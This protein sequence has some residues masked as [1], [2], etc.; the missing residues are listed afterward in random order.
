MGDEKSEGVQRIEAMKLLTSKD[1]QT[2]TVAWPT[3][4]LCLFATTIY[5]MTTYSFSVGSLDSELA[6]ITINAFSIFVLFTP[7]HDRWVTSKIVFE[8]LNRTSKCP[9]VCGQE[10][11]Q[12]SERF[13]GPPVCISLCSTLSCISARAS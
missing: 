1:R 13:G 10:T 11:L 6:V 2:P 8:S 12:L 3:L 7:M 5:W 4:F 9:W